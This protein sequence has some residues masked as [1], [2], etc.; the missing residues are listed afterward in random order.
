[1]KKTSMYVV[2]MHDPQSKNYEKG[3]RMPKGLYEC[4]GYSTMFDAESCFRSKNEAKRYIGRLLRI[5]RMT[6]GRLRPDIKR[7]NFTIHQVYKHH[8]LHH[9]Y[10]LNRKDSL[11]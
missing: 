11:V 4:F 2:F 6:C 7:S 8:K 3:S 1:M 10:F 9:I 5:R